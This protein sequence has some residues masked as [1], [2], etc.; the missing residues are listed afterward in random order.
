MAQERFVLTNLDNRR[1]SAST[2]M[3]SASAE[4][5]GRA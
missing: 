5:A 1:T 4:I 3:M 2:R